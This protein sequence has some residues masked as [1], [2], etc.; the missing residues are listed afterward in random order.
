VAGGK[1]LIIAERLE[2]KGVTDRKPKSPEMEQR[3]RR[4]LKPT[5]DSWRVDETYIRV[6]GKWVY[7]YRAVDS[8]GATIDF[9][10]ATSRSCSPSGACAPIRDLGQSWSELP[11]LRQVPGTEYWTFPEPPRIAHAKM[12]VFDP[13]TPQCIYTAIE[14]GALLKTEDGGQ[15]WREL[16]DYSKP[17]DGA[18]HDVHQVICCRRGLTPCS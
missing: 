6:K 2:L 13:R 1:R 8:T 9:R 5:N 4:R 11:A 12:M 3:L 18:Y 7:L 10:T 16:A 17:D 14:Q 15:S